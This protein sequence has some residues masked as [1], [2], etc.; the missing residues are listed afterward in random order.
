MNLLAKRI[1]CYLVIL[2]EISCFELSNV[3]FV[4]LGNVKILFSKLQEK[5]TLKIKL[6]DPAI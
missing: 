2:L 1:T 4:C 6:A 3:I 5:I